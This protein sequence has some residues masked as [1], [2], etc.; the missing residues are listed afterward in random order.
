MR[1]DQIELCSHYYQKWKNLSLSADT[2][3]ES[4]KCLERAFFWL[5][6][7]A[8]FIILFA[9]E[10]VSNQD[11]EVKKKLI[12]AKINLSKRLVEYANEIL[13]ELKF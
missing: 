2:I 10:K 13:K 3:E 8:A 9:I 7:Q 5:E 1:L 6:L 12:L 11:K 4:R